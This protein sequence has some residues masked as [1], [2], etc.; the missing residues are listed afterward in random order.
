VNLRASAAG[1]GGRAVVQAQHQSLLLGV[2]LKVAH[3]YPVD[4]PDGTLIEL[5]LPLRNDLVE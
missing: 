5:V 4:T 3:E 2:G 1:G